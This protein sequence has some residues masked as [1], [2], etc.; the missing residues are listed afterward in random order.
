MADVEAALA[1]F[2]LEHGGA[3][4]ECRPRGWPFVPRWRRVLLALLLL[5]PFVLAWRSLLL[6]AVLMRDHAPTWTLGWSEVS[7]QAMDDRTGQSRTAPGPLWGLKNPLVG[8]LHVPYVL[9][10]ALVAG[11]LEAVRLA[12]YR[13][14]RVAVTAGQL[15]VGEGILW[16]S[17]RE[18]LPRPGSARVVD[19]RAGAIV[20]CEHPHHPDTPGLE[21]PTALLL[22]RL[23]PL[24]LADL[25]RALGA[26]PPVAQPPRRRRLAIVVLV[27]LGVAALVTP[28]VAA[29][30][31]ATVTIRAAG[32]GVTLDLDGPAW[33]D[34]RSR[35]SLWHRAA[36]TLG[37]LGSARLRGRPGWLADVALDGQPVEPHLN[38]LR[39]GNGLLRREE[40]RGASPGATGGP[41]GERLRVTGKVLLVEGPPLPFDVTLN[42]TESVTLDLAELREQGR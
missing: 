10:A 3:R 23:D 29:P 2:T 9:V 34:L 6:E 11:A 25:A 5:A 28:L 35:V 19:G 22:G 15:L 12:R 36:I 31:R 24:D 27:A 20:E 33:G 16:P 32:D 41:R 4:F 21:R 42:H 37:G 14:R 26:P 39:T 17:V 7:I 8:G 13:S 30:W 40:S 18:L 1:S 38:L